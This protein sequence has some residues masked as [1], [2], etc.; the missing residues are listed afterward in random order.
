M[1]MKTSVASPTYHPRSDRAPSS[2]L[3]SAQGAEFRLACYSFLILFFELGFIRYTSAYVRVFG[4]Y[5]NFVL[6]AT[7]LGIG[8]GM[9]RAGAARLLKWGAVPALLLIVGAV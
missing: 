4:F 9:L 2:G 6:I 5:L 7:F 8:V 1:P 3:H